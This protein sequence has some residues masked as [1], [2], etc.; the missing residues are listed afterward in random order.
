MKVTLLAKDQTMTKTKEKAAKKAAQ[1]RQE[2]KKA[3]L[4]L[5]KKPETSALV[6]T[7]PK[8]QA[9]DETKLSARDQERVKIWRERYKPHHIT[10]VKSEERDGKSGVIFDGDAV[11]GAV[12]VAEATGTVDPDLSINLLSQTSATFG[13]DEARSTNL[14]LA[15]LHDIH[16]QDVVEGQL[17]GQMVG[18][19]NAAMRFLGNACRSSDG[20]QIQRNIEW[21]TKLMR[22]YTAQ[23]EALNRYRGK[24]QQK[25][26]VE[27]VHVHAGGQAVVGNVAA[28]PL[29]A[30][31]QSLS[32]AATMAIE[33]STAPATR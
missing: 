33:A 6:E 28:A 3:T 13:S 20:D 25:V 7:K 31:P 21:A 14:A 4:A 29:T 9:F 30:G 27:H 11:L 5:H 22:T 18:T 23:M 24:G 26:T 10:K 2:P 15:A 8:A 12:G 16:P 32:P 1:P 17:A 19:H